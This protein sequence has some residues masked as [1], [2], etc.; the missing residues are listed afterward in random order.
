ME[1]G[2]KLNS[3]GLGR[4]CYDVR[5]KKGKF[6]TKIIFSLLSTIQMSLFLLEIIYLTQESFIKKIVFSMQDWQ[7]AHK[8]FHLDLGGQG[9]SNHYSPITRM[10]ISSWLSHIPS[11][12]CPSSHISPPYNRILYI[13]VNYISVCSKKEPRSQNNDFSLTTLPPY[14][15]TGYPCYLMNFSDLTFISFTTAPTRI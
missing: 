11:L 2:K 7:N 15:I 4:V 10:D 12:S 6:S 5:G 14:L 13:V 9:S 3:R 1:R 8:D